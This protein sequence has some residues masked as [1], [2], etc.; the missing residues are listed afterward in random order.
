MTGGLILASASRAR[1]EL[2]RCAGVEF[3]TVPARVDEASVRESMRADGTAAAE[4]AA[5]LAALKA[6]SISSRHP[7]VAVVGADQMLTCGGRWFDKPPDRAHARAQLA[8]LRGREHRL[9]TAVCVALGGSVIWHH[10]EAA[11]MVMR[12]FGD[13][14]LDAYLDTCGDD[15]LSCVGAY[16]IE[17]R[18]VQLFAAVDGDH[19]AI[20]GLPLLPLLDFLRE[21]GE[22][23]R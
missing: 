16:R 5:A 4:T 18:G 19:F 10:G 13:A 9:E 14:F 15:I 23:A 7:D 2:L 17:D 3:E 22:I 8:A 1:G 20:L 21:R 6:V 12:P 11:R